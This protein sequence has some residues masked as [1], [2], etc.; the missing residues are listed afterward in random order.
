MLS[1]L[2]GCASTGS[3]TVVPVTDV[4]SL[5]GKWA[6]VVDGPGSNQQDL[7]EMTIREDGTYDI[8]TSRTMGTARGSGRITV[9]DGQVVLQGERSAGVGTLMTGSG[10]ERVLKVDV[11][12]TGVSTASTV[13]A[14]LRPTR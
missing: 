10:G 6:G 13:S 1:A 4:K 7:V 14:N 5:A 3:S 11:K 9:R 8:T 2:A 12:F